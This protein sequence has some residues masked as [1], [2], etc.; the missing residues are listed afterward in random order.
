MKRFGTDRHSGRVPASDKDMDALN[1]LIT[2][3]IVVGSTLICSLTT[4]AVSYM[5][6]DHRLVSVAI[7]E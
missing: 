4:R 3:D 7:E 6:A 1:T 2:A 5:C